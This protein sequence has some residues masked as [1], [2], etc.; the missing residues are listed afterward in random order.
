MYTVHGLPGPQKG[1]HIAFSVDIEATVALYLGQ[2][3]DDTLK[4]LLQRFQ[5]RTYVG[6]CH[7]VS[8]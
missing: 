7:D 4:S 5:Q 2:E 1:T 3:L 6:Y 8:R